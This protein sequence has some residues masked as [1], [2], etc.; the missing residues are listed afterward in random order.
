MLVITR[1]EKH[2]NFAPA[3]QFLRGMN[4]VSHAQMCTCHQTLHTLSGSVLL[5][6][7]VNKGIFWGCQG[8]LCL[9]ELYGGVIFQKGTGQMLVSRKLLAVRN[10][11]AD[12]ELRYELTETLTVCTVPSCSEF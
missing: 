11:D 2:A 1:S 12:S 9:S 10:M 5:L 6:G 7:R 3:E 8:L 4:L